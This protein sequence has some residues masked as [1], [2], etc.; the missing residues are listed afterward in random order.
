MF[1]HYFQQF[2]KESLSQKSMGRRFFELL[3]NDYYLF[4]PHNGHLVF[5]NKEKREV[6]QFISNNGGTRNSTLV[7]FVYKQAGDDK[8]N[9]KPECFKITD[10]KKDIQQ[11]E[12]FIKFM[13]KLP[14]I[15]TQDVSNKA[16]DN[17]GM[18]IYKSTLHKKIIHLLEMDIEKRKVARAL[19]QNKNKGKTLLNINKI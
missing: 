14:Q 3:E 9:I 2:N 12:N 15:I 18:R 16:N 13:A 5:I 19:R 1:N 17:R 10:K 6:I 11:G 8:I 4:S 7:G